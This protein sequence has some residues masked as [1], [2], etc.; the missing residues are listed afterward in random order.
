MAKEREALLNET[1]KFGK[2]I[3]D[4]MKK[5]SLSDLK[6][7]IASYINN[8]DIYCFIN[9]FSRCLYVNDINVPDFLVKILL[10]DKK[11]VDDIVYTLKL[12][13]ES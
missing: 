7:Y 4:E 9:N 8:K 2:K 12:S 11:T 5:S 1:I 10:Y 13:L 3:K 6:R